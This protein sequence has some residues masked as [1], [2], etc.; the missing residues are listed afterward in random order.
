MKKEKDIPVIHTTI[1]NS[2]SGDIPVTIYDHTGIPDCN[3]RAIKAREEAKKIADFW[4]ISAERMG[5]LRALAD[6]A[7]QCHIESVSRH[8]DIPDN[9]ASMSDAEREIAEQMAIES[10]Y[11]KEYLRSL[12]PPQTT[13]EYGFYYKEI[14]KNLNPRYDDIAAGYY[15]TLDYLHCI[16]PFCDYD[17]KGNYELSPGELLPGVVENLLKKNEKTLHELEP[18]AAKVPELKE[19]I[20]DLRAERD[21][22]LITISALE[23][24]NKRQQKD[25]KQAQTELNKTTAV[26]KQARKKI[27]I[28][29]FK[30]A[31]IMAEEARNLQLDKVIQRGAYVSAATNERNIKNWENKPSTCPFLDG[32]PSRLHPEKEFR[33]YIRRALSD[34]LER[35]KEGRQRRIDDKMKRNL[36]GDDPE[37]FYG[38]SL[39]DIPDRNKPEIY[40]AINRISGTDEQGNPD[41]IFSDE[42]QDED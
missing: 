35:I 38:I 25:Q 31:L 1:K 9:T 16:I 11:E 33:I 29:V 5:E 17:T 28:S 3:P 12:P 20:K 41:F 7:L 42:K 13:G 21:R 32:F 40:R 6:Y 8:Y 19:H 24:L 4:G 18:L 36:G 2:K 15:G 30:A 26:L 10:E 34:Y 27:E 39:D 23:S 14:V 22:L 37:H